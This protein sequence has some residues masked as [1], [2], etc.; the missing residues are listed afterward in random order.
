MHGTRD[1]GCT[2]MLVFFC[3]FLHSLNTESS[4]RGFQRVVLLHAGA[5]G[6]CLNMCLVR[7]VASLNTSGMLRTDAEVGKASRKKKRLAAFLSLSSDSDCKTFQP[8]TY[9]K[10]HPPSKPLNGFARRFLSAD[11]LRSLSAPDSQ[12]SVKVNQA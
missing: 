9:Q 4:Q 5:G 8:L 7:S 2:L 1:G 12:Q 3:F 6:G 11:Q 10:F